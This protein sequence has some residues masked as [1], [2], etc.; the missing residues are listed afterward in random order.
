MQDSRLVITVNTTI[1][2]LVSIP[3]YISQALTSPMSVP[4][5]SRVSTLHH[6][7][8][9]VFSITTWIADLGLI[10][11]GFVHNR[12]LAYKQ[13]AYIAL[14]ELIETV[15]K[16]VMTNSKFKCHEISILVCLRHYFIVD[17][18]DLST[19]SS[20]GNFYQLHFNFNLR[21]NLARSLNKN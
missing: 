21:A 11:L 3:C 19:S 6:C 10:F 20:D 13:I 14:T 2:V 18:G 17:N 7:L 8:S 16:A 1:F 12:R 15:I 5:T 4:H 9:T